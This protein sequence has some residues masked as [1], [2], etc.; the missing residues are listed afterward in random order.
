MICVTGKSSQLK[1]TLFPPLELSPSGEW[2]MGFLDMMTYNS[3]PNI[4]EGVNNRLYFGTGLVI[5]IPTGSYEI[6]DIHNYV[7][8]ELQQHKPD[9]KFI[10]GANNNTLKSEIFCSE[11]IDFTKPRSLATLL[12]FG[13]NQKLEANKWHKSPDPVAINKVDII[14]ITCNIVKGSYRDGV[15]GHVLH[16]FYP[17]VGSGY[18]IV[19][20]PNIVTYL[21]INKTNTLD[22]F[23]IRL[24]DQNGNLVNFRNENINIR[25][26][27]KQS[28]K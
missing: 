24:E 27:I 9:T 8:K 1:C 5:N 7:M 20:K 21:P 15:E 2:K 17:T 3:I 16:E 13:E 23:Y 12:G 19:E 4:E 26:D 28:T 22:E 18:K 14:R 25:V 6:T 10:L 11:E